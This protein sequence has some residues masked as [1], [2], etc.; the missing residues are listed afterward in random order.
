MART[1]LREEDIM[2]DAVED[3]TFYVV[4]NDLMEYLEIVRCMKYEAR[5]I[6]KDKHREHD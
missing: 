3:N 1:A 2:F 6:A 5:K 4:S